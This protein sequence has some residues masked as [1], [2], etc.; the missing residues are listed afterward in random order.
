[1]L[2]KSSNFAGFSCGK[3][4]ADELKIDLSLVEEGSREAQYCLDDPFFAS[5]GQE[6][7]LGGN[8]T[9]SVR[10]L[11]HGD[12][13]A[14]SLQLGGEV[15]VTCDRCLDPVAIDVKA[16][17][18]IVIMLADRSDEDDS[19]IYVDRKQ[20]V[21]DLGWLLYEEIVTALPVVC[22]HREGECNPQMEELLQAHLCT[23]AE[24]QDK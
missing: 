9:A 13:F 6:T 17:D 23:T 12:S 3:M 21:F 15:T 1:M 4:K 11:R 19:A 20:P 22:C 7:V 2:K 24:E 16:D 14:L 8:V 18:D 10:L 5:L